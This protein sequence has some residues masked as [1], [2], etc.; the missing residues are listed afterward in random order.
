MVLNKKHNAG[1]AAFLKILGS[2]VARLAS[3]VREIIVAALFGTSYISDVIQLLEGVFVAAFGSIGTV[4]V[5]PFMAAY[6]ERENKKEDLLL[7]AQQIFTI[8]FLLGLLLTTLVCLFPIVF[9]KFA[10][11]GF[12]GQTLNYALYSTRVMAPLIFSLLLIGFFKGLFFIQKDFFLASFYETFISLITLGLLA[13]NK[14]G[15]F[16]PWNKTFA[17]LGALLFLWLYF[18]A[19]ERKFLK[20]TFYKIKA[21]LQE[22]WPASSPLLL[23]FVFT[24][25]S[26]IVDKS[27]ASLLGPGALSAQGYSMRIYNLP[28]SIWAMQISEAAFPFLVEYFQTDFQKAKAF[29]EANLE[30]IIFI[31]LP[32][33]VGLFILANPI[34]KLVYERGAFTSVDTLLVGKTLAAYALY[35]LFFSLNTF[36]L[37]LFYARKFTKISAFPAAAELTLILLLK[38]FMAFKLNFGIAGLGFAAGLGQLGIFLG[39]GFYYI[40]KFKEYP[41]KSF[42]F[43]ILKISLASFAMGG[44]A[45]LLNKNNYSLLLIVVFSACFYGLMLLL[46]KEKLTR[47]YFSKVLAKIKK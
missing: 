42:V 4:I 40:K 13:L 31:S 41:E 18:Y 25:F 10:A 14:T 34:V 29:Y 9:L 32:A 33:S 20:L 5:V 11:I 2:L 3:F 36:V 27:L 45:T 15:E 44:L 28:F 21:V 16:F 1:Q 47:N 24:F 43:E 8:L 26:I 12:K 19:K 35:I 7:F 37:N 6:T 46:L 22:L 23:S 39:L 30:K 17:Y 38:W